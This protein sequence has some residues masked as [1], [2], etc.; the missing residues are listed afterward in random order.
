MARLIT[1]ATSVL[2]D[3]V[4]ELKQF[5]T[6]KIMQQKIIEVNHIENDGDETYNKIIQDLFSKEQ[7]PVE[8]IKW[9]EIIENMES[10]LDACEDIA[11]M[12][13]GIVSKNV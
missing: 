7:N 6:S 1:N 13:E 2:S 5:K 10:T 9:K 12:I 11:N 4:G 8:I 3:V